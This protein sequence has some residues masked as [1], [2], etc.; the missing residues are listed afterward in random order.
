MYS[1]GTSLSVFDTIHGKIG[2][3]ICADN[4]MN[5]TVLAE[6]MARMGCDLIVSPCSWAVSEE[7]ILNK[8]IYGESWIKA[9]EK[10]VHTYKLPMIG[11][12]N[13]GKITCGAWEGYKCIGNSIV[14]SPDCD[15][16]A[17]PFGEAAECCTVVG[18]KQYD[19]KKLGTQLAEAVENYRV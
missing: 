6:A 15:V 8:N 4:S 16:I 11:V 18:I 3:S 12:S 2:I 1:V 14:V 17:L 7:F 13:V 10:I 9:Y 19:R 5:S